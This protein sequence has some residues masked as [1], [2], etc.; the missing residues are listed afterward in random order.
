VPVGIAFTPLETRAGV[1]VR[2]AARADELGVAR[3]D[4]A[5]AWAHDAPLL[6]AEIA[7]HTTRI[8][9]GT[10]ILSMWGGRRPRWR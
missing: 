9:L 1:I 5:E 4:V 10:G 6:L 3:V 2:L 8:G 7:A